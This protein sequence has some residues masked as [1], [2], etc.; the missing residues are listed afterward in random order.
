[1]GKSKRSKEKKGKKAHRKTVN[2]SKSKFY[3]IT[4]DTVERLGKDCPKC[5]VGI[6]MGAHKSPDGRIRYTCGKCGTTIWE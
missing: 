3:K 1:M 6:K 4:G 5:G 2:V